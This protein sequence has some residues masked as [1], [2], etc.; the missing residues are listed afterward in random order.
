MIQ[1]APQMPIAPLARDSL[2]A[3]FE[4][5]HLQQLLAWLMPIIFA[6]A[7]LYG[8]MAIMIGDLHTGINALV[9][10]GYGLVLLVARYL[11]HIDH[12]I[13]SIGLVC[14]GLLVAVL[15]MTVIQPILYPNFAIVP[16]LVAAI[17]FTYV[18][19]SNLRW[20]IVLCWSVTVVITL[21]GRLA[22]FSSQ[23]PV[24]LSSTLL[25]SS[26]AATAGF[27]LL[28]LWQ[29]QQGLMRMLSQ[30]QTAHSSLQQTHSQLESHTGALS[31][32]L[33]EVEA[34]AATQERLL[35]E[36]SQQAR[37]IREL[38]V[39]ILALSNQT[40]VMPLVGALDTSRLMLLQEQALQT[41]EHTRVR[42][43]ILDITG[44]PVVDTQV[45]QGLLSVV[46]AAGL[47]GVEVRLVGIRPEVAQTIV[48]LGL[49]LTGVRTFRD[50]RMA[51]A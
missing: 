14:G 40:L 8:S 48:G 18:P 2:P 34:R 39:P 46:Q 22:P 38:S 31:E 36:N 26:L 20:Q 4:R 51:L 7:V 43:L 23:L 37:V 47:L 42:H 27:L 1:T 45:A 19:R 13:A 32:A 44:V 15:L 30:L 35:M 16:L 29:S 24:W 9:V 25:V 21:L 17:L 49:D 5:A 3:T 6:F 28:L 50:L 33:R 10:F 41:L 11:F 12:I